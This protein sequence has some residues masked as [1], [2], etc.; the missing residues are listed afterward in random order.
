MRRLQTGLILTLITVLLWRTTLSTQAAPL[1]AYSLPPGRTYDQAHDLGYIDWS[2]P[3]QYVYPPIA[4]APPCR[5]RRAER[6]VD[7]VVPNGSPVWGMA[8]GPA[9]PSTGMSVTLR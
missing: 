9:V 4:M 3:V 1:T 6:F 7:R 8:G 2:G 5:L